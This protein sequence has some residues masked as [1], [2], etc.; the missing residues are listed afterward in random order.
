MTRCISLLF[1]ASLLGCGPSQTEPAPPPAAEPSSDA[2]AEPAPA[3]AT[4][5]E[6]APDEAAPGDGAAADTT[7]EPPVESTPTEPETPAP[8]PW[9]LPRE[10]GSMV[11]VFTFLG[12]S[13]DG[14]R[15]AFQNAIEGQGASCSQRYEVFVVDAATD[16]FPEG[17]KLVVKHDHPEGG[18][19]GCSPPTLEPL[20]ES[21]RAELLQSY[22]IQ[23]G[24]LV[25]PKRIQLDETGLFL[26]PWDR[27]VQRFTFIVRNAVTDDPY[28]EAAK[29]GASYVLTL[30]PEGADPRVIEPGVRRRAWVLDYSVDSAPF[31]ASPDGSHGAII[32][33]RTE[34]AFEG[35]RTSYM[36]NGFPLAVTK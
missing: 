19:E 33:R 24:N 27:G 10:E 13:G 14:K 26:A 30:H 1:L 2:P 9:V 21:R 36:S 4:A 28:G 22:G 11:D 20:L 23:V 31:F 17:G 29:K 15:Y 12:W 8:Q 6:P 35:T 3:E 5:S 18:P 34:T 16:S 32:V 7:P 25:P